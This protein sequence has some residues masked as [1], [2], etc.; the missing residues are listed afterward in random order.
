MDRDL[1]LFPNDNTGDALWQMQQAGDEL[2]NVREIE[3]SVLFPSQALALQFGQLLLENNQK[4][5]CTPFKDNET[6]PW[7]ITA[8]PEIPLNYENISAYKELLE[9]SSAP[10]QGEFDGFYCL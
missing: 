1:T 7:E 10:L 3:F 2:E 9:T 6:L 4:L 5:S 8:Y